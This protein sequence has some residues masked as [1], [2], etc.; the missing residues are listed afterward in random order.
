MVKACSG[1]GKSGYFKR[2]CSKRKERSEGSGHNWKKLEDV[3]YMCLNAEEKDENDGQTLADSGASCYTFNDR[4]SAISEEDE[5][6]WKYKLYSPGR[7]NVGAEIWVNK[8][9]LFSRT[10]YIFLAWG[11]ILS[12][13]VWQNRPGIK[14]VV[15]KVKWNLFGKTVSGSMEGCLTENNLYEIRLLKIENLTL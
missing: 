15:A 7:N 2:D 14:I 13:L 1:F 10:P 3:G 6:C 9:E 5:A 8:N 4:L 12:A 11:K